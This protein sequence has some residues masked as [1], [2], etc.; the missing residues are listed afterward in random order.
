MGKAAVISSELL[1][2]AL[3]VEHHFEPRSAGLLE[4]TPLRENAGAAIRLV[5]VPGDPFGQSERVLETRVAPVGDAP[6]AL[7]HRFHE[8]AFVDALLV[9]AG[10]DAVDL[11][12]LSRSVE[13]ARHQA[14]DRGAV[15]PAREARELLYFGGERDTLRRGED[16]ERLDA[17]GVARGEDRLRGGVP[18]DE[19][20]HADETAEG[21][22]TPPHQGSQKHLR[23]GLG[24]EAMPGRLELLAQLDIVIDLTIVDDP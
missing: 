11:A 4:Y 17:K 16:I 3:P 22:L 7:D 24:A 18:Y 1:V 15:E 8:R 12:A 10:A 2:G 13:L 5:L 21:G 23:I 20:E 19:S 9:V 14:D 6:R